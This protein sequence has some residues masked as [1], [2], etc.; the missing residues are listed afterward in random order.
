MN[1]NNLD[2]EFNT[3]INDRNVAVETSIYVQI[4]KVIK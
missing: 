2:F 4:Q 1:Y 3:I